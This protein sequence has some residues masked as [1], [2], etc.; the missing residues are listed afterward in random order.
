M[1]FV[2]SD[3]KSKNN[4]F[5]QKAFVRKR[6]LSSLC[7]HQT[8]AS[9]RWA[10]FV[11]WSKIRKLNKIVSEAFQK[12][13]KMKEVQKHLEGG[14]HI[15]QYAT[16]LFVLASKWSSSEDSCI[17]LVYTNVSVEMRRMWRISFGYVTRNTTPNA[18][19]YIQIYCISLIRIWLEKWTVLVL[20]LLSSRY[21]DSQII[22]IWCTCFEWGKNSKIV[23]IP[24]LCLYGQWQWN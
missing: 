10:T 23:D 21:T 1:P 5:I 11:L 15:Q 22:G 12:K 17:F 2:E 13:R 4:L 20:L 3:G 14:S 19:P 9:N 24:H 16:S 7:L 6:A 18:Q 8:N